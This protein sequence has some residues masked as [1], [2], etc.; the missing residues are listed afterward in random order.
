MNSPIG[1]PFRPFIPA[2]S[3]ET[4]L[5]QPNTLTNRLWMSLDV[6]ELDVSERT[7][8]TSVIPKI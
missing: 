2:E 5:E 4:Y 1:R 6:G 8:I 7:R 3:S